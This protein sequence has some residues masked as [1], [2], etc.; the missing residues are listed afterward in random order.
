MTTHTESAVIV[1]A[2]GAGTRMRSDT[3]KVLHTLAGRSMLAHAMHAAAELAPQ[4]LVVVVG[5]DREQVAPAAQQLGSDLGRTID[6]AVQEEQLGTGHAVEMRAFGTAEGIHR[7]RRGDLRRCTAARRRY[8]GR[9]DHRPRRRFRR[10]DH[11]DYDAGRSDRL[12]AHP[13]HAGRRGDRHRRTGRRQPVAAGHPRDQRRASM[14]S[15]SRR[16]ARR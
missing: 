3:N 14:R 9:P 15:T 4:H 8:A 2:A 5:K 12:R 1:L 13:A 7:Q 11:A 10:C 6:I 16:C